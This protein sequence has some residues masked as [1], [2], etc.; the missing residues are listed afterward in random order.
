MCKRYLAAVTAKRLA[1]GAVHAAFQ[2]K[3]DTNMKRIHKPK[4]Q[5]RRPAPEPEPLIDKLNL[6]TVL[7]LR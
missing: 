4:P 5:T 7:G 1:R 6:F 2:V 3:G